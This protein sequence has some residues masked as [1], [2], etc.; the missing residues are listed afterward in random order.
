MCALWTTPHPTVSP[1][2]SRKYETKIARE[3]KELIIYTLQFRLC[4]QY[5]RS[6]WSAP[7]N[8]PAKQLQYSYSATDS[9][10]QRYMRWVAS[11][12]RHAPAALFSGKGEDTHR[13]WGWAR[14]GA[15][16]EEF[17]KPRPT[18][19]RAPDRPP[20]CK[21]VSQLSCQHRCKFI[22]GKYETWISFCCEAIWRANTT[23]P[24]EYF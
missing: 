6:N 5:T 22:W 3:H 8:M 14:I 10:L 1:S 18:G 11:P 15:G 20:H 13:T 23:L 24:N 4:H 21:S 12:T 16:V 19:V 17:E 9:W 7:C 2:I